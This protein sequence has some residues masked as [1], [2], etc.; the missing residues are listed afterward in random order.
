MRRGTSRALGVIWGETSGNL[1]EARVISQHTSREG[2]GC[3]R[4]ASVEHPRAEAMRPSS[5]RVLCVELF[6]LYVLLASWER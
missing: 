2:S 5:W 1:G 6:L 3:A 4:D